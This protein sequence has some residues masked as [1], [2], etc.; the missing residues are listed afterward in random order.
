[1]RYNEWN[2]LTDE[3]KKST[4]WKHHPRVKVAT[5]FSVLFAIVF[6]VALL[7]IFKNKRVHVNR[8]PNA[9][10]AF[11]VSKSIV[12]SKLQYPATASFPTNKYQSVIDTAA[13]TYQVSST[14]NAQDSTGKIGKLNWRV[15]L[16]YAGG[17]WADP[18]SWSINDINITP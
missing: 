4:H 16:T 9:L 7:R 1:M 17:D 14:L 6:A 15:Q 5:I 8:Q 12:K 18:K 11:T 13:N 10:E 2:T 3:Q